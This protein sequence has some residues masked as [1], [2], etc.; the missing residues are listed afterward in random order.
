MSGL[1]REARVAAMDVVLVRAA[2][3]LVPAGIGQFGAALDVERERDAERACHDLPVIEAGEHEIEIAIEA[4]GRVVEIG[5]RIVPHE[6]RK[7][8]EP[9]FLG[10]DRRPQIGARAQRYDFERH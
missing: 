2:D 1:A 9:E 6:L 10:E 8:E 7:G 3:H 5:H 4:A